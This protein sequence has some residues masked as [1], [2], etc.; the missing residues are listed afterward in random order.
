VHQIL[1]AKYGIYI[2][3]NLNVKPVLDAGHSEM[4]FSMG[5]AK[6]AG[7]VQTNVNPVGIV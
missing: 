7:S 6:L 2:I 3:E 5:V 4:F 1:L